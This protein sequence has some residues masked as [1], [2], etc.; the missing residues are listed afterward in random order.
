MPDT[1]ILP[2]NVEMKYTR[3]ISRWIW[4]SSSFFFFILRF[5]GALFAWQRV[6]FANER[7]S[8]VTGGE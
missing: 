8:L 6:V 5:R 7:G 4:R 2:G 1:K 3:K